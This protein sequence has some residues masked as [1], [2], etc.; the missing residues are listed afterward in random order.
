MWSRPNWIR[1][2]SKTK[3]KAKGKVKAKEKAT[4]VPPE[5]EEED[6]E[7]VALLVAT[8]ERHPGLNERLKNLEMHLALRYDLFWFIV[9]H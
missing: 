9:C 2:T 6:A 4:S 5:Q 8:L 7:H 1:S 3:S